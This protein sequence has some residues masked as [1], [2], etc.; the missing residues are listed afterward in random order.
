MPSP[1]RA[2]CSEAGPPGR[3]QAGR[4]PLAAAAAAAHRHWV[5]TSQQG[6]GRAAIAGGRGSERPSTVRTRLAGSRCLVFG[7]SRAGVGR[8]RCRGKW[9]RAGPVGC[10][11]SMGALAV[12]DLQLCPG[13]HYWE[14]L[15]GGV[16][17]GWWVLEPGISAAC[18][19]C[20]IL[21]C[22]L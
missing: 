11:C 3:R 2:A 21:Q 18:D 10:W 4:R 16:N 6:V 15:N 8:G 22:I 14:A 9:R 7:S 19:I 1:C 13:V 17:G 20:Y 12:R 5:A